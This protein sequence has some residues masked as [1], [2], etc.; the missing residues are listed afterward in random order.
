MYAANHFRLCSAQNV[1]ALVTE[2]ASNSNKTHTVQTQVFSYT[3]DMPHKLC[4]LS[5]KNSSA[6]TSQTMLDAN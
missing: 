6:L 3:K 4:T 1:P 2:A 5:S